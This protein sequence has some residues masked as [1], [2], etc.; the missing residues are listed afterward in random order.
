MNTQAALQIKGQLDAG[1][2]FK[3]GML[4]VCWSMSSMLLV[5]TLEGGTGTLYST[6]QDP[7]IFQQGGQRVPGGA[8]Y[9]VG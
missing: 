8:P 1:G 6:W 4:G 3:W 9:N 2:V 7:L 5:E